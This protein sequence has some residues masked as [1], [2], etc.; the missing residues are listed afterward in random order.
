MRIEPVPDLAYPGVSLRQLERSDVDDWYAYLTL[1]AVFEHTSWDLQSREELLAMFD[2]FEANAAQSSRRLAIVENT[3]QKLIGTI[4]F[5]T[6]SNVNRTAE[7][8]YDL[9]P[10]YWGKGIARTVCDAVSAWSFETYGF[11]RIQATVLPDNSRSVQVLQRCRYQ[12][13]GLLRCFRMVR[14]TPRDFAL[15]SRL[16]SD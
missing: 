7:I 15:Y 13:E 2:E 14:G 10:A 5:H 11:V 4:G 6:I 9:S 3:G 1:P 8:S 12:Y 16:M